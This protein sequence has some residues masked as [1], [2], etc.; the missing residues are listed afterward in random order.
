MP[1]RAPASV[2]AAGALAAAALTGGPFRISAQAVATRPGTTLRL[3]GRL[4]AQVASSS[5]ED[6]RAIDLFVRRARV[7]A[8]VELGDHLSGRLQIEFSGGEADLKDAYARLEINPFFVVDMGQFKRAF[9]PFELASSTELPLVERDGRID[10]VDTCA[11][12]RGVCSFSRFTEKLQFS[13]RDVGFRIHG[14]G[15]EGAY[16]YALTLTNGSGSNASDENDAKSAAGRVTVALGR[17]VRGGANVSLHDYVAPDGGDDYAGAA[18]VDLTLGEFRHGFRLQAAVAGGDHWR[19]LDDMGDPARFV[20]AQALA[21]WYHPLENGSLV[22]AIE[23]V[24]RV[25]WG[26]PDTDGSDDA[27]VLVTP[28]FIAYFRGRNRVGA[29]VDIYAQQGGDTEFSFKLMWFLH[30]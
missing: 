6:G 14:E 10:G 13:E 27:G 11:G 3:G 30:F 4:H 18:G 12:I 21:S 15:P 25:S 16:D 7:G 1:T 29:N 23:P 8:D 28:G 5:A 9:D 24:G 22:E 2:L 26:D 17:G 19:L 20:I